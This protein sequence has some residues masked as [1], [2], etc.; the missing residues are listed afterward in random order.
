[1]TF[2]IVDENGDAITTGLQSPQ[3]SDEAHQI[4]Q[5]IADRRGASVWLCSEEDGED[6]ETEFTPQG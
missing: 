2:M 6:G 3:I 1:M 4:A 5:S